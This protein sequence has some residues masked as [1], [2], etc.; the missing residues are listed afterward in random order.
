VSN[1]TFDILETPCPP[2][3]HGSNM[4]ASFSGADK[5]PVYIHIRLTACLPASCRGE[6]AERAALSSLV[7]VMKQAH[8]LREGDVGA[9]VI[10]YSTGVRMEEGDALPRWEALPEVPHRMPVLT[11]PV[12]ANPVPPPLEERWEILL[13]EIDAGVALTRYSGGAPS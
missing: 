11:A 2:K 13:F 7:V 1:E 3:S 5:P 9:G 12:R 6:G 4:L 8:L 10:P